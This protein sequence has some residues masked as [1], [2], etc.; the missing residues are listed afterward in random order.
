MTPAS[1]QALGK[2][3]LFAQLSPRELALIAPQLRTHQLL[4]DD[5][6]FSEGEVARGCYVVLGGDV[7]VL[8]TIGEK[9]ETIAILVPGSLVGHFSLVDG[10]PRSATCRAGIGGAR[11]LELGR[12]EFDMLFRARSP[13]AYKILDQ[14]ALDLAARLRA[15][16]ERLDAARQAKTTE[17]RRTQA[18]AAGQSLFGGVPARVHGVDLDSIEVEA[19]TQDRRRDRRP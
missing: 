5:P 9:Q 1:L 10:K 4:P 13:F 18:R 8:K 7:E 15:V 16:N 17:Q 3:P 14:I 6:L 2:L 11:V 19:T 12:D